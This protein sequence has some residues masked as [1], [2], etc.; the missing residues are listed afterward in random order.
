MTTTIQ[1]FASIVISVILVVYFFFSQLTIW[2]TQRKEK[3]AKNI[4]P[5]KIVETPKG[6]LIKIDKPKD[7]QKIEMREM[8]EC[9]ERINGYKCKKCSGTGIDSW[10]IELEQFIY[11]QCIDKAA[12]KA[13]EE[14]IKANQLLEEQKN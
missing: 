2:W 11:C 5:L 4:P 12:R 1:T 6:K 8:A 3:P 13:R 7:L 14:K 9:A 10:H